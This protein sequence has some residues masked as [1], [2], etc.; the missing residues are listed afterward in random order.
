MSMEIK[1]ISGFDVMGQRDVM[2]EL[3]KG[4]SK[5]KV[6]LLYNT[7]RG[8][9]IRIEKQ[10]YEHDRQVGIDALEVDVIEREIYEAEA[11][12]NDDSVHVD[13]DDNELYGETNIRKTPF[14]IL[15]FGA[16]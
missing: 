9:I 15:I 7:S 10:M 5:A 13:E 2:L 6:A 11:R 16:R 4:T 14:M 12:S 8:T 3:A 1:V